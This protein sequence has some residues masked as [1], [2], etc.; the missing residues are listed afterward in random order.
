MEVAAA[1]SLWLPYRTGSFD[2]VISIAVLHHISS[3]ERRAQLISECMRVVK[4]GGEA[5]FYAWAY[6]QKNAKSGHQFQKQVFC[7][8]CQTEHCFRA[9]F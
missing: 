4:V 2:A 5:L 9:L 3:L 7:K 8:L 1:D 6:E